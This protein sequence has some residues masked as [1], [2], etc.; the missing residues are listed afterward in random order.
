[1]KWYSDTDNDCVRPERKGDATNMLYLTEE[2]AWCALMD[3][4]MYRC[5]HAG[6]CA[7]NARE[8]LRKLE[9]KALKEAE[10]LHKIVGAMPWTARQ[11]MKRALT[12]EDKA[13]SQTPD[14]SP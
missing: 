9:E 10:R 4:G 5:V 2:A 7:T 11:F 8:E 12:N 6:S 3:N 14:S 1:M 13:L